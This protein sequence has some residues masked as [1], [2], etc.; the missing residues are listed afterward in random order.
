MRD[1]NPPYVKEYRTESAECSLPSVQFPPEDKRPCFVNHW[2][3]FLIGKQ[4]HE[5][6]VYFHAVTTKNSEL[7]KM[8]GG[9]FSQEPDEFALRGPV[10]VETRLK[11]EESPKVINKRVLSPAEVLA[12]TRTEGSKEH[13]YVLEYIPH[14]ETERRK[15]LL[16]QAL[17]VGRPDEL[18]KLL[19]S[20]G[21]SVLH[22]YKTLVRDY[23]DSRH[24]FFSAKHP[25]YFWHCVKTTGWHDGAFVLP[26]QIIGNTK[27]L[28]FD[29]KGEV[30]T[31]SQA[32]SFE[33]WNEKVSK[34]AIGNPFLIFALCASLA[35]PLLKHLGLP[36]IGFHFLGDSTS[37]KTTA[38][39]VGTS[40]WGSPDFLRSWRTTINALESQCAS[41]CDTIVTLDE[42][43]L[44]DHKHLDAGIY[45]LVH[46]ASKGRLNRD[47][48]AKEVIHWR[49]VILSS[50]ER[51][52][53]THL[54]AAGIDHKA[55]QAVRIVD[56]LTKAAYGIFD[57]LHGQKSGAAFADNLLAAAAQHYGQAGPA[58][59]GR[60][61]KELPE[62]SLGEGLADIISAYTE[63]LS[64]QQQRVWRS[65]ATVALAGE[66]AAKWGIL[67]WEKNIAADAARKLFD[68]WLDNQSQNTTSR[69]EA[70]IRKN[71]SDFIDRHGDS[72]F[73]DID[74]SEPVQSKFNQGRPIIRDRAGYWK[75]TPEGRL[76]LFTASGL[77]E[78]AG[79][80]E[81]RRVLQTLKTCDALTKTGGNE[82]A[83]PERTPD[84][85]VV[86]LY[87]IDPE[88]L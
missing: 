47:S 42:S 23:L 87:W 77:R 33:D 66:L 19:R 18:A 38:L 39:I 75:D 56:I 35:G 4:R 57:D 17:L 10:S 65:F 50:G 73:S 26:N 72:R 45:L 64:A 31:Y 54:A 51:S 62:L 46:G 14:G 60:L 78:A 8:L 11:E 5:A 9:N 16:P 30:A 24:K 22:R 32:G 13:S 81:K 48:T 1:K 25:E 3:D 71:I 12:I 55:G 76:F 28:Y 61:T 15:L 7:A 70:Q 67:P 41:R 84:G 36:G 43:H 40:C 34:P 69:E 59:V 44:A 27:G 20:H 85:R 88:A 53:E 6:G 82:K 52:L 49:V 83:T 37:G 80:F 21:L 29:P 2:S 74:W 79:N 86:K 58:F 68:L 63:P